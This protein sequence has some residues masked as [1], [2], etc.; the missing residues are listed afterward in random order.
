MDNDQPDG[1]T[2]LHSDPATQAGFTIIPNVILRARRLS[3]GSRLLYGLLKM[4]AW[5]AGT[6]YPGQERLADE[7]GVSA[8]QIRNY[9]QELEAAGLLRVERRGLTQTNRYWIEPIPAD[10]LSDRKDISAQEVSVISDQDRKPVSDK[11]DSD[12]ED[13]V[14]RETPPAPER[15]S[16]IRAT[17]DISRQTVAVD[18]SPVRDLRPVPKGTALKHRPD[19]PPVLKQ[20]L[21]PET[22][23]VTGDMRDWVDEHTPEIATDVEALTGLFISYY[24]SKG[25]KRAD[26]YAAWQGFMWRKRE[27][28]R[29]D[30]ARA[31]PKA[32]PTVTGQRYRVVSSKGA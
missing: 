31:A 15:K 19:A 5:Q 11:E 8:R 20:T 30:A 14:R 28:A 26:W 10:F 24:R 7:L 1:A 23:P 17:G 27:D 9:Q 25:E 3:P 6:A 12:Q 2:V 18:V 22:F 21:C 29:K 16:P 13:S 4:Y 32:A